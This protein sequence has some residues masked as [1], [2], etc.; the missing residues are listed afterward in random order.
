[1]KKSLS[2]PSWF[3]YPLIPDLSSDNQEMISQ[4]ST[5]F[6]LVCSLFTVPAV[7]TQMPD[8][9]ETLVSADSRIAIFTHG[10]STV[11][12]SQVAMFIFIKRLCGWFP[13]VMLLYVYF[14]CFV[15]LF[16]I[17][18]RILSGGVFVPDYS[19]ES[20]IFENRN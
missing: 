14:V 9:N 17:L 6:W 5:K 2:A 10:K 8:G 3:K 20:I 16:R 19:T 13:K 11:T 18:M 4:S 1:M 15:M 12:V 7:E